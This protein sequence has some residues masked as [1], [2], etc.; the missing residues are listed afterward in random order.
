MTLPIPRVAGE[1]TTE[2]I[3][4]IVAEM[5]PGVKV[6]GATLVGTNNYG[7]ANVS[8]SARATFELEYAP[9]STP[10]FAT[11][12]VVKMTL[13]EDIWPAKLFPIY[14]NEINFYRRIRPGLD[15]EVPVALGARY[16]PQSRRFMLIMEDLGLRGV[17]F[18]MQSDE[19]DV[20]K[21]QA[22]LDT[23]AKLHAT[24][25]ESPR[26]KSDL[27]YV[28]THISGTMEDLMHGLVR[29]GIQD[30]LSKQVVKRELMGRL[31]MT[32]E[33]M[34]LATEAV[35]RHQSTL[36][37]TLVHGDSHFGNTY[38]LPN[39]KRGL[40]DWQLCVRGYAMHDV[41]YV[42]NTSLSIEL[43]R[44]HER[45]ILAFYHDRLGHYGVANPPDVETLWQEHRLGTLWTFYYGWLTAPLPNYGW[46]LLTVA[47]LRT[48]AAFE[49]HETKKALA[50]IM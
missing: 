44:K 45:D 20:A 9:G 6:V 30:E 14:E 49:D 15:L 22:V 21:T 2:L 4:E 36:P 7:E 16:D 40:C 27:A 23:H 18:A 39:G 13:A 29:K 10:S 43:R 1:I 17:K 12:V 42:I 37:Q 47:L 46:E 48:S 26:F 32:E 11:R 34:F 33:E 3:A 5:H 24:F 50:K 38:Y 31:Q 41:S 35:K 19:P 25:W 8:S 28:Q